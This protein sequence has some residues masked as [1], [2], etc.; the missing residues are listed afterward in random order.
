[1]REHAAAKLPG[2]FSFPALLL[3]AALALSPSDGFGV[4][5]CGGETHSCPCAA[6][7]PCI[8]CECGN[9]VWWAWHE[10]CCHWDRALEW[11]TDAGTWDNY[12]RDYG[13]PVGTDP[14]VGSIFVCEPS[15]VCSAWGHVGWLVGVH[16]DG[17]FDSTEMS[18]SSWCGV[19][20]RTRPAGF[21]EHFIYNPDGPVAIDNAEFVSETI[22]DGTHF[23]PGESFLKRWTMRNTGTTTWTRDENYLWT[24]D[25][26]ERFSADEQTLLPSGASIA[27]NDTHDWDVSMVAPSAPG[28]YR[29]YWIMDH[30]GEGRFGRRVWV[31][32]AVDDAPPVDPQEESPME[33]V[34]EP[35]PVDMIEPAYDAS[36]D[37]AG[38]AMDASIEDSATPGD[39]RPDRGISE[40]GVAGGCACSIVVM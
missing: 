38:D 26:D 27:P 23:S 17:S 18:C 25:G 13:Y 15:G 11:C 2:T 34:A 37:P 5:E 22:P 4:D 31:E 6:H 8:C 21:A 40:H 19:A 39:T 36:S 32:I 29:G 10:A 28:T 7:T 24:W 33:E 14:Q 3:S 20:D 16:A 1:M 9:C 30:S 35:P 12:A